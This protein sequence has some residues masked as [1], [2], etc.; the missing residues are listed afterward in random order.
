LDEVGTGLFQA[1]LTWIWLDCRAPPN[2]SASVSKAAFF[3]LPLF[4]SVQPF[5]FCDASK[6][7]NAF[8]L[9]QAKPPATGK[10]V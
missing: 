8:R 4:D 1:G 3:Q 9:A 2:P 6:T 5:P 7:V 10:S